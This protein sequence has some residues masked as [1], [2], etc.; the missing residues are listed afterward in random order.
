MVTRNSKASVSG[1]K[2]T[3]KSFR[4]DSIQS[5]TTT[6]SQSD[7]EDIRDQEPQ[8]LTAKCP[9]LILP[10][11]ELNTQILCQYS[12]SYF[13]ECKIIKVEEDEKDEFLYTIHYNGWNSRYDEVITHSE[14]QI[15]FIQ[16]TPENVALAKV[17]FLLFYF[18]FLYYI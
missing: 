4:A 12:D 11:Y 6:P 14:A 16:H 3:S 18:K 8:R 13:Y 2:L 17:R 1:L 9:R 15:K 10:F 7:D 5:T